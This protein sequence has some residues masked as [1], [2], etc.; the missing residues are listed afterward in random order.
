M[1]IGITPQ[2]D[3]ITGGIG[4]LDT[5]LFYTFDEVNSLFLLLG[6]QGLQL[7]TYQ[8]IVDMIFPLGYGLPLAFLQVLVLKQISE[9]SSRIRYLTLIPIAGMILDY[10]EN[11]LI[12]SQIIA[13]PGLSIIVVG[14]AAI[15]TVLKWTTL[16]LSFAVLVVT[17]IY[18]RIRKR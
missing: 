15:A 7:Y 13:F 14:A 6:S 4:L 3:A 9:E 12:W 8:K 18:S 11:L 16:G 1:S 17:G 10:I 5:R 2:V